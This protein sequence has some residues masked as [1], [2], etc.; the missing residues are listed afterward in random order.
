M[1]SLLQVAA[2]VDCEP[3]LAEKQLGAWFRPRTQLHALRGLWLLSSSERVV[4]AS[5][6]VAGWRT[7]SMGD[8]RD[9]WVDAQALHSAR[10]ARVSMTI[11]INIVIA[12]CVVFAFMGFCWCGCGC[13]SSPRPSRPPRPPRPPRRLP[14]RSR[15]LPLP[16]RPRPRSPCLVCPARLRW[17]PCRPLKST[18][19]TKA[20]PW[21][22]SR[23][24][25]VARSLC[26]SARISGGSAALTAP[27]LNGGRARCSRMGVPVPTQ[28]R[29][30]SGFV[31]FFP[32]SHNR[33]IKLLECV[34]VALLL[35]CNVQ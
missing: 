25:C 7:P 23:L 17:G 26:C 34:Q 33:E 1:R 29:S 6:C 13:S 27:A 8:G 9:L 19:S 22:A 18:G 32:R 30:L 24:R 21:G 28:A 3:L 14:L 12:V 5:G 10:S 20:R 11:H 4:V 16:P 2:R 31:A 35:L 15:P